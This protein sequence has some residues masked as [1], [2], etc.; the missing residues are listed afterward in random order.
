MNV[1]INGML[2]NEAWSGV[3]FAILETLRAIQASKARDLDFRILMGKGNGEMIHDRPGFK[4]ESQPVNSGNRFLRVA[5]EQFGIPRYLKRIA[6]KAVYHSPA[7]ILPLHCPPASIVTVHDLIALQQPELCQNSTRKYFH[8]LLPGSV[9]KSDTIVA[10]SHKVKQ[11]LLDQF[12]IDSDKVKVIHNGVKPAFFQP[13][14]PESAQGLRQKYGLPERFILFVGVLE[15]KKNLPRLLRSFCYLKERGRLRHKLVIAG[16]KG[17]KYDAIFKAI[18]KHKLGSHVHLTGFFPEADLPGLYALADLFVFPSLYEGF[19]M[20]VL[21]AM[22][23][24]T[25]VVCSN[26]GALP[27][28]SGGAA[29]MVDPCDESAL[30]AAI[31]QTLSDEDLRENLGAKGLE[32]A[33]QFSWARTAQQLLETYRSVGLKHGIL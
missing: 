26:R 13:Q 24:G 6:S 14:P 7:Y 10:I 28:V 22:A 30:A 21:E 2:L 12:G 1:V 16:Q 27:E 31:E 20:P 19:G 5:W 4:C 8:R 32:R 25:P 3:H 29:V 11:D 23:A 18:E 9:R 33:R 17:W 15:P